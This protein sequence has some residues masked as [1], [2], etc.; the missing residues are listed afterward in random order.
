MVWRQGERVNVG[1][2]EAKKQ[3]KRFHAEGA[4]IA[5]GKSRSEEAAAEE[6]AV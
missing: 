1:E 2:E 3:K 6:E 4:E 5:E